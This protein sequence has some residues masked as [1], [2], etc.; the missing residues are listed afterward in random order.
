MTAHAA[1]PTR[2]MVVWSLKRPVTVS[3]SVSKADCDALYPKYMRIAPTTIRTSAATLVTGIVMA[4]SP[5][6]E[7]LSLVT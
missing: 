7:T 5:M 1:P 3:V 6:H 2:Y 4:E